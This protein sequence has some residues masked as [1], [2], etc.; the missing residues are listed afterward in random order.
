MRKTTKKVV[1]FTARC[2]V[3]EDATIPDIATAVTELVQHWA[4]SCPF[5]WSFST[6]LVNSVGKG[7]RRRGKV[8][9]HVSC[10]VK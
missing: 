4:A 1:T 8:N 7:N 5:L 10:G 2:E 9:M 3:A 6:S